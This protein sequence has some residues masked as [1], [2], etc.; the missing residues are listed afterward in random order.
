[1]AEVKGIDDHFPLK[2][3]R[4]FMRFV[5]M[6]PV[7][8]SRDQFISNLLLVFIFATVILAMLIEGWDFYVSWGDLHAITYNA[9]TTITVAIELVKLT[10]FVINRHEVLSFN[11]YTQ[12]TFWK[13]SYEAAE[14]QI[15]NKCNRQKS[16][17]KNSSERMLPFNL[18]FDLPFTKT[19]YYEI[20][21]IFE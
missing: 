1:M 11:A 6:W 14:L 2:T 7:D 5:G 18:Y 20:A 4:F 13:I 19:P 16:A 15:L 21:F 17:G 8:K 9:P 3:L 10:K 12:K